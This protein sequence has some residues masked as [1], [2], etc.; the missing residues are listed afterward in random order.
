[1]AVRHH[2]RWY[3]D[4]LDGLKVQRGERMMGFEEFTVTCE[5][6][7]CL[8]TPIELLPYLC[9]HGI[10]TYDNCPFGCTWQEF[11]TRQEKLRKER[12]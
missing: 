6:V 10:Y 8:L 12:E 2:K 1:M 3:G 11:L 5:P 9:P 4:L 7:F